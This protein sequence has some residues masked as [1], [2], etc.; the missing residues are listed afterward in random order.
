V[1]WRTFVKN[2]AEESH[3]VQYAPLGFAMLCCNSAVCREDDVVVPQFRVMM[4][5]LMAVVFG[6]RQTPSP[7]VSIN[8]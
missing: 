3:V 7:R 1:L 6:N 4:D 2:D 8:D 5:S